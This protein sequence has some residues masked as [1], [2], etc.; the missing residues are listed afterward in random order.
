MFSDLY[1]P[2]ISCSLIADKCT[3]RLSPTDLV[4]SQ[5]FDT[6]DSARD[7]VPIVDW[8]VKGT[9]MEDGEETETGL[10]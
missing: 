1:Q 7:T 6:I 9:T 2:I 3:Y 5:L 10:P 8:G 4:V